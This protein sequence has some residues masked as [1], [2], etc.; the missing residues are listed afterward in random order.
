MQHDKLTTEEVWAEVKSAA[1]ELYEN[2]L[3]HNELD[4]I[5]LMPEAPEPVDMKRNWDVPAG[6]EIRSS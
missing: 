2:Y 6:L 3:E 4:L 5:N 1:E